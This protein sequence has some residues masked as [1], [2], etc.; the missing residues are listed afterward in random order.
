[1]LALANHLAKY[2]RKTYPSF[3]ILQTGASQLMTMVKVYRSQLDHTFIF[4]GTKPSTTNS[5]AL[6]DMYADIIQDMPKQDLEEFQELLGAKTMARLAYLMTHQLANNQFEQGANDMLDFLVDMDVSTPAK[7]R[8]VQFLVNVLNHIVTQ[9][10]A[11]C[12]PT[13]QA[14]FYRVQAKLPD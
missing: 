10:Y 14:K 13:L 3:P 2:A 5:N 9:R 11:A 12:M 4:G 7:Q 1:M 8:Y 6:E